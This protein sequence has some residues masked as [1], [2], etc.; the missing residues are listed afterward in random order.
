MSLSEEENWTAEPIQASAIFVDFVRQIVVDFINSSPE[1]V[2]P[3][4]A[5]EAAKGVRMSKQER[6]LLLGNSNYGR[7]G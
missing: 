7:I 6:N 5:R 2:R 4:L 3:V 1:P